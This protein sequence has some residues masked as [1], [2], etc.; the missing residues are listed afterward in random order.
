MPRRHFPVFVKQPWAYRASLAQIVAVAV[1]FGLFVWS[2][3]VGLDMLWARH[4]GLV[5]VPMALVDALLAVGFAAALLKLI[6]AQRARHRKI[7][8]QLKTIAEMNH[9][10]HNA[11]EESRSPWSEAPSDHSTV[12]GSH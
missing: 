7:I 11:L 4:G 9:H 1:V 5:I 8:H 3:N 2:L 6:L 12:P 10:I